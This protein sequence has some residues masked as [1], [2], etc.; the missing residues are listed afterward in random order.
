M[1]DEKSIY[2]IESADLVA[3]YLNPE[4]YNIAA[5]LMYQAY[6]ND[7]LLQH[8]LGF[9]KADPSQYEKKL[10]MLIREELTSFWQ[11]QQ[12]IIGIFHQDSLLAVSCVLKLSSELSANRVWHWRLK[13]MFGAG[14]L[15]TK[16]LIEKE[17]RIRIALEAYRDIYFLS[18]FAVDPH[19]QHQGLGRYLLRAVD[20]IV[21]SNHAGGS[22]IFVTNNRHIQL[23]E[24]EGYDISEALS[25]TKVTGKLLIKTINDEI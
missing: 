1:S 16:Q 3:R 13:L 2:A 19:V 18:L 11:S 23:F 10:R 24:S 8:I 12:H 25:F 6:Q 9:D 21:K 20:D 4:D 22:A 15:S 17:K 7:D 5:S 14:I